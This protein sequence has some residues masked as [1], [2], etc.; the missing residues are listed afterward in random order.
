MLH[1]WVIYAWL[2]IV[3]QLLPER[4]FE[5][6]TLIPLSSTFFKGFLLL[7]SS[8]AFQ[9]QNCCSR[10]QI[11]AE[12]DIDS[13]MTRESY[14]CWSIARDSMWVLNVFGIFLLLSS[15]L[16]RFDAITKLHL[17]MRSLHNSTAKTS[18]PGYISCQFYGSIRL[19]ANDR[20]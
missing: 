3:A 4:L 19:Q 18:R 9:T 20:D 6:A 8:F 17:W 13:C 16:N 12:N 1:W 11:A 7:S 2:A 15:V 14:L 5:R 10:F